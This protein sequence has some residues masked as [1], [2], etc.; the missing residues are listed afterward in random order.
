MGYL[1]NE[2][3]KQQLTQKLM[4]KVTKFQEYT[5]SSGIANG[6]QKNKD[7]YENRFFSEDSEDLDILN[8]GEQGEIL[9]CAL[10]HFR[11]IARHMLN[12]IV[13]IPVSYTV[14]ATNDSVESR[15]STQ[16][17]RQILDYYEK[18]K[19]YG[20]ILNQVTEYGVIYGAGFY[21]KE[22]NPEMGKEVVDEDGRYK[23][24]GDFDDEALSTWDV[25]Y[26]Y[27]RKGKQDW[28]I[29]RR[30]KNKYD[31]ASSFS[32]E[33]KDKI[34][35]LDS[36]SNDPYYTSD[37]DTDTDDIWVY[38]AYH[39][40]TP[41]VKGGK[42]VLFCGGNGS[43]VHLYD[44]VNIH[45]E[46]LPVFPLMPGKYLETGMGYTDV[47]LLRAPQM[48]VNDAMSSLYTNMQ[49]GLNDVWCP[50]G[51]QVEI[52]TLQ[53]GRNLWTSTTKPEVVDLM[54]DLSSLTNAI[55]FMTHQMETLSAQNAVIRGDAS[56]A[57]NLKSGVA[58]QTVV[59][60][61][62]QFS[63]GLQAAR[64]DTFE[65]ITMFM[66]DTLRKFAD[67]KRLIDILGPNSVTDVMEFTNQDLTG[68]SRVMV[69]Q[70]NPI[71]NTPA[72]RIET[73]SEYMKLNPKEFTYGDFME[74]ANTGNLESAVKSTM[75]MNDYIAQIKQSLMNGE[76]VTPIAG[77]NH[78]ETI[79]E[80]QS[81]L[82]NIKFSMDEK[83]IDKVKNITKF[84]SDA[85]DIMRKGDEV[86]NLIYGGQ[87]PTQQ[88]PPGQ[89]QGQPEP[90]GVKK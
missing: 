70:V 78:V 13:S 14:S 1:F 58:L 63:F 46:S 16:I 33:K 55:S 51:D 82:L 79:K 38:S 24:E 19:R 23:K 89:N 74:V 20:R 28:Y 31:V 68:V 9:A 41:A 11:N 45:G 5:T 18:V 49:N 30:R 12:P 42:Y 90:Q 61:G 62:Q 87:L 34:L 48:V 54:G 83:N 21:V 26:D 39:R 77:T 22:W 7:F 29:F 71:L 66:L 76:A 27:T 15:R 80:V 2:K 47:N 53:S 84:I 43:A 3:D 52:E 59:A 88:M 4:E 32:G 10:G 44:S 73:A 25:F 65:D 67:T 57:P 36:F 81:L 50:S 69:N 40:D 35:A 37:F 6:W 85:M 64:N 75:A 8:T 86:A 56:A 60:M 72:G 17:F